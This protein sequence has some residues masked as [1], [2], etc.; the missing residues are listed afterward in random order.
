MARSQE[1]YQLV[2]EAKEAAATKIKKLNKQINDLGGPAMVKSQREVK[3]LESQL[4]TL[5]RTSEKSPKIFT[6]FTKGI[7]LGNIAATAATRA[8]GALTRFIKGTFE[9]ALHHQKVWNDVRA[10]LERHRGEVDMNVES[11]K[12]FADSMQTLSGISDEVIGQ[13][14][15]RLHD[16]NIDAAKS[17]ELTQA[18]M[19]VAAA[20]G[21]D[22]VMVAD[23]MG[24][25]INSTTN[26]LSRYGIMIDKS[27]P[28]Q[29]QM[30]QLQKQVNEL[31]GGAAAARM[32]TTAGKLS[33]LS[34]RMG[35]LQESIGG[36]ITESHLFEGFL[37]TVNES[38]EYWSKLM[39]GI[40]AAPIK[41]QIAETTRELDG[42]KK[43]FLELNKA[44]AFKRWIG[45]Y[46]DLIV[47]ITELE[48]KL[49][50]LQ[51]QEQLLS[52]QSIHNIAREK[53]ERKA[54]SA[55]RFAEIKKIKLPDPATDEDMAAE[56]DR[57]NESLRIVMATKITEPLI[58]VDDLLPVDDLEATTNEISNAVKKS[59][60]ADIISQQQG[61]FVKAFAQI[62]RSGVDSLARA[63]ASGRGSIR[64]VFNSMFEDFVAFFIKQALASVANMFIPGLGVLLGGIFDTP[65]YDRLAMEQ[66]EHFAHY[67][68]SGFFNNMQT[69]SEFMSGIVPSAAN[70]TTAA[71]N[72]P[73][74]VTSTPSQNINITFTGNV[75]SDGFIE[76]NVVPTLRQLITNG[77]TDIALDAENLTG[78]RN[79]RVY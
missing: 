40:S 19:D 77:K 11:I 49:V 4:K 33:L 37:D 20:K 14:F 29:D 12:K 43:K 57:F 23:L 55:E 5:N 24:K 48:N 76:E 25:S 2:L 3:R 50:D 73:A 21:M 9:A 46:D 68:S 53:A 71:L 61:R 30:A 69:G 64:D 18:A 45:G 38:L 36:V 41:L 22:V 1:K 31:F 59:I 65:R 67:F 47:Q 7:A 78:S 51:Y 54:L 35:D 16:S 74:A 52:D 66:G 56:I 70:L 27:L 26:A 60:S 6:R 44:G 42:L 13:A 58:P 17:M 10:S 72:T 34:E 8:F 62:G 15:Q 28:K 39:T 79:I 32:E 63:I 75:L